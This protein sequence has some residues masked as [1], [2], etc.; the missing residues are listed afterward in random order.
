MTAFVNMFA[1]QAV[2][3][4]ELPFRFFTFAKACFFAGLICD[5]ELICSGVVG[6]PYQVTWA[7]G[8]SAMGHDAHSIQI[9]R[10]FGPGLESKHLAESLHGQHCNTG[11]DAQERRERTSG[12][13]CN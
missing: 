7:G 1:N 6:Y 3:A 10:L 2:P 5:D 4:R 11:R 9:R 12:V 8:R 13:P